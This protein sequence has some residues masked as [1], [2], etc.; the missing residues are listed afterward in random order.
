M[1]R[2]TIRE[3]MLLTLVVAMVV[4]WGVDRHL[5]KNDVARM[6][7]A[8]HNVAW[9]WAREVDHLVKYTINGRQWS[10]GTVECR[11][12]QADDQLTTQ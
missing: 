7:E 1:F 10:A 8:A 4:G 3:M 5:L 11:Q 2:F 12:L 6:E 9:L